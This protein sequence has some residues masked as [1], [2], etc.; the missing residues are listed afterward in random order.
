M[1]LIAHTTTLPERPMYVGLTG[2]TWGVG[3]V[4]GPVIGGAFSDS[5][6]GWR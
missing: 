1:S 6:A 2:L 5:T 3:I 4:L